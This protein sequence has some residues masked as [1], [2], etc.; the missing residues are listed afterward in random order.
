MCCSFQI[1]LVREGEDLALKR[2]ENR[3]VPKA[4]LHII[5]I[6]SRSNVFASSYCH[7]RNTPRT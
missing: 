1:W 2:S 4:G 7:F 3:A 5:K 6:W